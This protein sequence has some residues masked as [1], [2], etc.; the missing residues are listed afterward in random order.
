ME[1]HNTGDSGKRQQLPVLIVAFII[2]LVV[3]CVYILLARNNDQAGPLVD[4]GGFRRPANSKAKAQNNNTA[5][6][7][8]NLPSMNITD[9]MGEHEHR[10]FVDDT[11]RELMAEAL[12]QEEVIDVKA[13]TPLIKWQKERVENIR[14]EDIRQ[15]IANLAN[16][17]D[18]QFAETADGGGYT[19]GEPKDEM[20]RLVHL[21]RVGRLMAEGQNDPDLVVPLLKESFLQSMKDWPE[22]L[23]ARQQKSLSSG[24][25]FS[26]EGPEDYDNASTRALVATYVLA[27]LQDYESL[28]ILLHSYKK[29]EKWIAEYVAFPTFQYLVPPTITLYAMHQLVSKYPSEG[30]SDATLRARDTYLKWSDENLPAPLNISRSAW[31]A[32]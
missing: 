21:S 11:M 14:R 20:F 8:S 7:N 15:V 26:L 27:E 18:N 24:G 25:S 19:P 17:D 10:Q 2:I 9:R 5:D 29:S 23:K 6:S 1:N 12:F 16:F 31:H 13:R 28:P 30:L 4:Q 3:I 32:E 22:A